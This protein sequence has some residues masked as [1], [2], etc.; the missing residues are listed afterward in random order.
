MIHHW[1]AYLSTS[2]GQS[3]PQAADIQMYIDQYAQTA[4]RKSA[5]KQRGN[6]NK[7]KT[8]KKR[9]PSKKKSKKKRKK[10]KKKK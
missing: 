7:E 10:T 5:T 2:D 3:D 4:D 1:S 9:H 8:K 6:M